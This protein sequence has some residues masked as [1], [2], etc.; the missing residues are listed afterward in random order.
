[1]SDKFTRF[2]I[3]GS[4][5]A[6]V[7]RIKKAFNFKK[8]RAY[9]RML[10]HKTSQEKFADIYKQQLWNSPESG[11]GV[12]SE[13][14]YT[15]NL[16]GWLLEKLPRYEVSSILD[17][18]CGDFNW[19]KR[20][21]SKLDIQYHGVDIVPE[22][23]ED[24]NSKYG[25][26]RCVFSTMDICNDPLPSGDLVIARDVLFHLSF[27]DIDKFLNNLSKTDYR[28]LLTSTHKNVKTAVNKDIV[29]GHFRLIDLFA[30]P[31][32]FDPATIEDRVADSPPGYT[33]REMIMIQK[34]CVPV[35]LRW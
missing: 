35:A 30:P 31:F 2:S 4:L 28:Y 15:E 19:M 17:T 24:N 3:S 33:P 14:F 23:I 9:S 12:G 29:T 32:R 8:R 18:A 6:A 11:S 26:D 5:F 13:L 16:R 22:V 1:M 34:R 21:I 27:A 7:G 10:E 25:S 20:V